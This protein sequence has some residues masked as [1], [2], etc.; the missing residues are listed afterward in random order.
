MNKE[1]PFCKQMFQVDESLTLTFHDD[2]L[3]HKECYN[4]IKYKKGETHV[5][6]IH[7][8]EKAGN[9]RPIN[10]NKNNQT[11]TF[12]SVSWRIGDATAINLIGGNIY[13]HKKKKEKS[14]FGGVI[15]KAERRDEEDG[16]YVLTFESSLEHNDQDPPNHWPR[17]DFRIV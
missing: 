16:R 7:I 11:N 4:K 6:S 17:H 5:S 9:I 1:C 10:F 3:Y 13:L 14:Y 2:I 12:E 15:T 8:I